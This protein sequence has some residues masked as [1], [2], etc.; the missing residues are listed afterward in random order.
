MGK[1]IYII[2]VY[3]YNISYAHFAPL[4]DLSSLKYIYLSTLV[5]ILPVD[6]TTNDKYIIKPLTC[7]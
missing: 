4:L 2:R 6:V 7:K 3:L 5:L 1:Y